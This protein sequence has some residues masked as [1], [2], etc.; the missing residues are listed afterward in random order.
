MEV[1]CQQGDEWTEIR[2]NKIGKILKPFTQ[3]IYDGFE[4]FGPERDL[5]F[6]SVLHCYWHKKFLQTTYYEKI[7]KTQKIWN[8][9]DT[10]S[11]HAWTE[12]V[13]SE[14]ISYFQKSREIIKRRMTGGIYLT[15]I[16]DFLAELFC[17]TKYN[18]NRF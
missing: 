15:G 18:P 6:W 3:W 7:V 11:L 10:C 5:V 1:I 9:I 14:E 8:C 13:T 17:R 12:I 16:S 2:I 4:V